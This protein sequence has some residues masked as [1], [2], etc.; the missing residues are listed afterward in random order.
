MRFL[1]LAFCALSAAANANGLAVLISAN[2]EWKAVKPLFA[3]AA[4]HQSPYGEYFYAT[5][6]HERVLFFHGGWGKVA[7]AGSTQYVIDHFRP[8]R[9]INLGTCG[10]VEGHVNRFD[11]VAP[12]KVV[13]YDIAE[14]MGDSQE[15]IDFYTTSL[16]LPERLPVPVIKATLYS[17]DRDLTSQGLREIESRFHP[18][19]VDWESGAM[20]WVAQK[21]HTPLLILRGVSDLVSPQTAEAQGNPALFEVNAA[22]VMQNLIRDLPQWIVAFRE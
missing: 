2:M 8:S 19:A 11:V 3:G 13:I 18:V 10:G 16:K 14:A 15:A 21:N 5:V 6:Q 7:A 22:R 1:A 12:E 20:A 9:L 4:I 17:A